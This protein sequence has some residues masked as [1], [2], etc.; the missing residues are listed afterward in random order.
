[1]RNRM[2]F[3]KSSKNVLIAL[4]V[5][6]V[7]ALIIIGNLFI[8]YN[9]SLSTHKGKYD[10]RQLLYIADANHDIS[11]IYKVYKYRSENNED[12]IPASVLFENSTF[13]VVSQPAAEWVL[14]GYSGNYNLAFIDLQFYFNFESVAYGEDCFQDLFDKTGYFIRGELFMYKGDLYL[15]AYFTD[16]PLAKDPQKSLVDNLKTSLLQCKTKQCL[17]KVNGLSTEYVFN[18]FYTEKTSGCRLYPSWYSDLKAYPE[19]ELLLLI[20]FIAQ[21][22]IAIKIFKKSHKN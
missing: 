18:N 2:A 5:I 19:I 22:P 9:K 17:F 12:E 3:S 10:Y 21:F 14:L 8:S 7:D 1:M 6:L 13:C 11:D 4:I 15:Y 16:E 20:L